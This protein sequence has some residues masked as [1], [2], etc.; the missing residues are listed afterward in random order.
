[1]TTNPT[2]RTSKLRLA[3]IAPEEYD[4]L[5]D[6]FLGDS[7]L[8]PE[9]GPLH[10][11]HEPEPRVAV[12]VN[13]EFFDEESLVDLPNPPER[14]SVIEPKPIVIKAPAGPERVEETDA[15][16]AEQTPPIEGMAVQ[17]LGRI[18]PETSHT[19]APVDEPIGATRPMIEVV[20]LGHLP[21]RATLWVRQYACSVARETGETVALIRAASGSTA[22]DLIDGQSAPSSKPAVSIQHALEKAAHLADRVILR[23]DESAEP[24]LLERGEID[25]LTILTGADETAV[26][27]SYRLIKSLTAS[28]DWDHDDAPTLRM[29]VMGGSRAQSTDARAKL[30]RAVESFLDRTIE[31][32]V[33]AGR[34]DATGT[35]NLYR[36]NLAHPATHI[37]DGLIAGSLAA[38]DDAPVDWGDVDSDEPGDEDRSPID[39]LREDID[40]LETLETLTRRARAQGIEPASEPVPEPEPKRRPEAAPGP[41]AEPAHRGE[42]GRF[43]P[44]SEAL[45]GLIT[46]L[47]LIET[48]CPSAPGVEL[49]TDDRGR[50]H[51][52]TDDGFPAPLERLLNAKAWVRDHLQLLLRA[53]ESISMPS[54]D[55]AADDEPTMHVLAE[56]P[57]EMMGV[58]PTSVRVYAMATVRVADTIAR[59]ATPI[60]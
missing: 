52:V 60:N 23:V 20:L 18:E 51:V 40:A 22:V 55:P 44:G 45:C 53:E 14:A 11:A 30:T 13:D 41:E 50:V 7:T 47:H 46:G 38:A 28:W 16:P 56:H 49:A 9:R 36:D 8:A 25:Q 54:A 32:V 42:R 12:V 35:M 33:S 5:A 58:Y 43:S 48:R 1:M 39:L 4:A 15:G 17:V 26:V 24:D 6:L 10:E 59:V 31:I 21:V 34:I 19:D 2:H 37:L 29:A 27:A 57:R 3:P